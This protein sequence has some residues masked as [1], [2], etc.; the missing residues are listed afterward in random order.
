MAWYAVFPFVGVA[1]GTQEARQ[2][3]TPGIPSRHYLIVSSETK[4][5]SSRGLNLTFLPPSSPGYRS[6]RVV[7]SRGS[8]GRESSHR[9]NTS[10]AI[11]LPRPCTAFQFDFS[12][13]NLTLGRACFCWYDTVQVVPGVSGYLKVQPGQDTFVQTET[14]VER[15][16][17]EFLVLFKVE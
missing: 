17:Y 2:P 1:Y 16:L 11:P 10:T 6:A 15:N 14:M 12:F 4:Q 9:S 5:P 8:R 13:A 7:P 3:P